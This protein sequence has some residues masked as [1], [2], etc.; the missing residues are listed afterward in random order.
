[1]DKLLL[2]ASEKL[3]WFTENKDLLLVLLGGICAAFGGFVSTWYL[4][5]KAR[6][7]KMAE[8]IGVQQVE[9]YKGALARI[10]ELNLLLLQGTIQEALGFITKN[11]QW[12]MDSI[13]LLPHKFV[14][15]WISIRSNLYIGVNIETTQAAM[16]NGAERSKQIKKVLKLKEHAE[17]LG[18]EALKAIEKASGLRRPKIQHLPEEKQKQLAK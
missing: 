11:Q 17:K 2:E 12:F 9:V 15:N 4:A 16:R 13:I 3:S 8:T 5:K 7:I 6:K 1:M 14:E 18:D 10:S